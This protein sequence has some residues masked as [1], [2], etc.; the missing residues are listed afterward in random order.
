SKS[1]KTIDRIQGGHVEI[2]GQE[3]PVLVAIVADGNR[4]DTGD[5]GL[6]SGREIRSRRRGGRGER[7][8]HRVV[9]LLELED[10]DGL[11]DVVFGQREIFSGQ[12]FERLSVF[13]CDGN[14]LNDKLCGNA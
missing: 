3:T 7:S 6:E 2:Q 1:S 14:R 11:R 8:Q 5:R 12:A 10:T 9:E 13:V 4:S